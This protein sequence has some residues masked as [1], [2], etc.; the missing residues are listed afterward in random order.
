M[1][2]SPVNGFDRSSPHS[3]RITSRTLPAEEKCL[4]VLVANKSNSHMIAEHPN[5]SAQP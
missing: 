2:S 5:C 1:F 3:S 4:Y